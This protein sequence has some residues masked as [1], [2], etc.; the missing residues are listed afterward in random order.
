MFRCVCAAPFIAT[1]PTTQHALRRITAEKGRP[2][3][4]SKA[5]AIAGDIIGQGQ[6]ARPRDVGQS[7]LARV[8]KLCQ[9]IDNASC[10]PC[11]LHIFVDAHI[12][13][14]DLP[15]PFDQTG[16]A[17]IRAL[18]E[19]PRTNCGLS[20]QMWVLPLI[21][22]SL[23]PLCLFAP[24]SCSSLH[25]LKTCKISQALLS[26]IWLG[27]ICHAHSSSSAA[28]VLLREKHNWHLQLCTSAAN[29]TYAPFS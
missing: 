22:E 23:G 2:W 1:R 21:Y 29:P 5:S 8:E 7:S 3:G 6:Q 17:D 14:D 12:E 4:S 28:Q 25:C 11:L 13:P 16:V 19:K 15:N 20:S 18:G 26:F 9:A 27:Q 24:Y 10:Q